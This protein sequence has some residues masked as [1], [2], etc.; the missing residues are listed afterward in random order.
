MSGRKKAA[1]ALISSMEV[2]VFFFFPI[3]IF[4]KLAFHTRLKKKETVASK[5]KMVSIFFLMGKL[6]N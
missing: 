3:N 1:W 2:A 5:P 6:T 4:S